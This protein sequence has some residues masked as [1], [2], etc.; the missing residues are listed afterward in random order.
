MRRAITPESAE[1]DT[2]EHAE[3][4][5]AIGVKYL[6]CSRGVKGFLVA[7]AIF[8]VAL[9]EKAYDLAKLWWRNRK[10]L[11]AVALAGALVAGAAPASAHTWWTLNLNGDCELSTQLATRVHRPDEATPYTFMRQMQRA[12][13]LQG[14]KTY[15]DPIIGEPDGTV[16]VFFGNSSIVFFRSWGTCK[17]TRDQLIKQGDLAPRGDLN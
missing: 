7:T 10:R 5:T 4:P 14:I 9:A 1:T 15:P 2:P 16:V 6:P 8:P 3:R 13:T 11:S 12:G 17:V